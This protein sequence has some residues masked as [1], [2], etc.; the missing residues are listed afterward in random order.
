[1]IIAEVISLLSAVLAKA[2]GELHSL[3]RII[4]RMCARVKKIKFNSL[5]HFS[6][7]VASNYQWVI[8]IPKHNPVKMEHTNFNRTCYLL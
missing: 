6:R 3:R 7:I 8:W 4:A 2:K 1:M 5:R